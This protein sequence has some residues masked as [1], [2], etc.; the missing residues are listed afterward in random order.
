MKKD[1]VDGVIKFH[2]E[3]IPAGPLEI[4]AIAE[5]EVW[6]M[7]LYQE[8]LIGVYP[9]GIG[10]GNVS[11][12]CR[13][14]GFIV[15]G[16]QTGGRALMDGRHYSRVIMYDPADDRLIAKGPIEA[17]SESPTHWALYRASPDINFVFHSHSQVMW[18]YCRRFDIPMTRE[19]VKCGTP[20]MAEE[21]QRLYGD[22][23]VRDTGIFGMGGHRDGMMTFGRTSFETG[24]R[25]MKYFFQARLARRIDSLRKAS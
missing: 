9:T 3:L 4:R 1:S 17:S 22:T 8:G 14:G 18:D 10:Y 5:L 24:R 16:S 21:V 7:L 20:E 2:Q 13:E 19:D 6:R 15:T 12:R 25:M 11:R 23:R